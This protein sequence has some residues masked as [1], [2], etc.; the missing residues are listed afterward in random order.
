VRL[1]NVIWDEVGD[2]CFRRRYRTFDL[3]IGVVRGSDSLLVID[4][5]ADLR[6]ADELLEDLAMFGRPVRWVVNSHW[7]FDHV[8]GNQRFVERAGGGITLPKAVDVSADLEIWGHVDLPAMLLDNEAELRATLRDFYGDEA[9][10]EYDRVVLTPPERLVADCELLDIGDRGVE[11]THFGRGHTGNDLVVVVPAGGV[12]F[13]GVLLEQSG[14]PAYG[15]DSYP[16]AWPT[17]VEALVDINVSTFVPGHGDVMTPSAAAEQ[18]EAITLVA[19]LIRALHAA[20]IAVED[21]LREAGDRWP[22]PPDALTHAVER[23]Y[24]WLG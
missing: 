9:G 23:G 15:D 11:L 7:H 12:V 14:P 2:G 10:A 16:L 13:A 1:A 21:A 18:A 19:S 5:R 17:T 22:F 20:G 24:Q 3:N 4:T 8:F 6:Q